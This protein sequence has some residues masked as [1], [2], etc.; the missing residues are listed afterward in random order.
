MYAEGSIQVWHPKN[1]VKGKSGNY[2]ICIR[3]VYGISGI[4]D[5]EDDASFWYNLG[6]FWNFHYQKLLKPTSEVYQIRIDILRENRRNIV[7]DSRICQ[8]YIWCTPEA[9]LFCVKSIRFI[10][11]LYIRYVL[12]EWH[13]GEY[14]FFK[15]FDGKENL[16]SHIYTGWELNEFLRPV[17]DSILLRFGHTT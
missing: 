9:Y 14:L 12:G 2:R 16:P 5:E 7:S 4:V 15:P 13:S 10:S 17:C 3:W 11:N 1:M 6:I 8:K